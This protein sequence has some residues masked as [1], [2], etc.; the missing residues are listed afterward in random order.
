VLAVV[1]IVFVVAGME[2]AA[3]RCGFLCAAAIYLAARTV[4]TLKRFQ[5]EGKLDRTWP[6]I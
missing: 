1:T 6:V 5:A 3:I 4:W 2:R